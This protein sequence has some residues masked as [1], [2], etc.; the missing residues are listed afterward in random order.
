MSQNDADVNMDAQADTAIISST[1]RETKRKMLPSKT[2]DIRAAIT[3]L[4]EL[5][6]SLQTPIET[7][8][9]ENECDIIGKHI[10]I[11]LKELLMPDMIQANTEMQ[12]IL[13]KYRLKN[14]DNRN[15]PTAWSTTSPPEL[16]I[17]YHTVAIIYRTI[18][19]NK[20]AFYVT[21]YSITS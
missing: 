12:Q 13:M 5:N 15:T 10:A 20:P 6:T 9:K 7:S 14:L 19:N 17:M 16:P 21:Y 8:Q 3:E 11:Q 4:K 18:F 2:S 1:P